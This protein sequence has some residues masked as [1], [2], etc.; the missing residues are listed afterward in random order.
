MRSLQLIA[1]AYQ[2]IHLGDD[3][4]LFSEG[5]KRNWEQS[6]ISV[7]NSGIRLAAHLFLDALDEVRTSEHYP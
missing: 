1:Q 5:G 2:L 3:A 7:V 4:V 6:E